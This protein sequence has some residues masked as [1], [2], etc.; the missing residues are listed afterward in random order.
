MELNLAGKKNKSV[1]AMYDATPQKILEGLES[2][3]VLSIPEKV[4]V[5][6]SQVG[7]LENGKKWGFLL[8][9]DFKEYEILKDLGYENR[10]GKIKISISNFD[11][12]NLEIYKDKILNTEKLTID[13]ATSKNR[14]VGIKFKADLEVFRRF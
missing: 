5:T 1:I 7:E 8:V 4:I 13:F 10:A 2:S 14:I 12:R 3:G 11:G 9:S 6:D